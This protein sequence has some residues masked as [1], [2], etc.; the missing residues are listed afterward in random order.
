MQ[1]SA[2]KGIEPMELRQGN[3]VFVGGTQG[4]GRAAALAAAKAGCAILLIARDPAAGKIAVADLRA[5]GASEATFL[6]ADISTIAGMETAANGIIAWKPDIHGILHSATNAFSTK[7]VTAD[8]LELAFA[9]Q[10]LARAVINRLCAQL[11]AACGDGRIVHLAGAVPYKMAR[12]DF[13]DL[14]FERR[15]G[16]S[17]R[18]S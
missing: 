1:N 10:Y 9:L 14:Q 18:P 6:P 12:P 2:Q 15:N 16:R 8:G 5:A 7:N 13:D 3:F 17:S 11:L 4:I